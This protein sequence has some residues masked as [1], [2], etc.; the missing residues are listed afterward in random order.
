MSCNDLET[1]NTSKIACLLISIVLTSTFSTSLAN[2]G[3]A[4][5]VSTVINKLRVGFGGNKEELKE[6][7]AGKKKNVE[8]R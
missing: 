3:M 4:T 8:N 2:F 6:K 5:F 1:N 7:H